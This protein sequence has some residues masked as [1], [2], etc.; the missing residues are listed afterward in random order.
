[1]RKV[2]LSLVASLTIA[3]SSL[4]AANVVATVDGENITKQDVKALL[5][6]PKINY[7]NLPKET[8]AKIVDQ[9]VEKKLLSKAAL[10]SGVSKTEAYKAALKKLEAE[11][12]LEVWM[13]QEFKKINV[14]DADVTAYYNKNK[15]QFKTGDMLEA[16]HILVKTEKEAKDLI[17][18]LNK[19]KDKKATFEELAK[20]H[21]T[22]PTGAK[23]G[24]LG[25]FSPK[26]MVPEF[27]KAASALKKDEYSKSPVKTQF[28][29]HIIYLENKE[30]SQTLTLDKVKGKIK[31]VLTQEQYTK[32]IKG[33]ANKLRE[34]AK[35]IIK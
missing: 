4:S 30:T 6:N 3:A 32:L 25:K 11:L 12:A 19:A 20:K 35:V 14:T 2:V 16:R 26:Q 28:G 33:Q 13:Q 5:R 31:Q 29:F 23:G 34:K 1:M 15:A 21:S 24:Y 22:G 9:L 27:S 10:N 7:D 17:A 8:Q 18:K